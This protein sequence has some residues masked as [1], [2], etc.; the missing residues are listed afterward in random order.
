M[1]ISKAGFERDNVANMARNNINRLFEISE[2]REPV[3][4]ASSR[5]TDTLE[6]YNDFDSKP[7]KSIDIRNYSSNDDT[8]INETN[9]NETNENESTSPGREYL[10]RALF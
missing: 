7:R 3:S 10:A 8:A 1:K 4:Q 9:E 2:S 6:N 5:K